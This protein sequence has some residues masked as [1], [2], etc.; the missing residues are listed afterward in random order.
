[1]DFGLKAAHTIINT[2]KIKQ[3]VEK[4]NKNTIRMM[5][6]NADLGGNDPKFLKEN[7]DEDVFKH[8]PSAKVGN[9]IPHLRLNDE[10]QCLSI[11]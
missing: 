11:R 10:E 5:F 8:Y 7:W 4:D 6:Q 2:D 1:M 3:K 9:L